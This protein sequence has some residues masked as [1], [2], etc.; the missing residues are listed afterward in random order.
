MIKSLRGAR[1]RRRGSFALAAMPIALLGQCGPGCEPEPPGPAPTPRVSM[2]ADCVL[3]TVAANYYDFNLV[4]L[5]DVTARY[6]LRDQN[7]VLVQDIQ[8]GGFVTTPGEIS[9]FSSKSMYVPVR[10]PAITTLSLQAADSSWV[11][12]SPYSDPVPVPTR[13]CTDSDF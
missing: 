3:S 4:N 13:E 12:P 9:G 2:V 1:A 7:G 6:V 11:N 10:T 5:E 8:L